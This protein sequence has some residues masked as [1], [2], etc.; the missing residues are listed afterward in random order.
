VSVQ[1]EIARLRASLAADTMVSRTDVERLREQGRRLEALRIRQEMVATRIRFELAPDVRALLDGEALQ[2]RGERQLTAAASLEID[3]VGRFEVVPGDDSLLTLEREATDLQAAHHD[4]LR[5]IGVGTLAAAES[6]YQTQQQATKDLEQAVKTLASLAPQGLDA[7]RAEAD[8]QA[9][10]RQDAEAL[11]AKLPAADTSTELSPVASLSDAESRHVEACRRLDTV[12]AQCSEAR[13]A[14]VG[15]RAK[16][17]SAVRERDALRTRLEDASRQQR[18][19]EA[20]DRRPV[21]RAERDTLTQAI[22]ASAASVDAA[23]PELLRQSVDRFRRSAEI[24]RGEFDRRQDQIQLLKGR[25]E[26]AGT[27]GLEE[28]RAELAV[29]AEGARRRCEE[30]SLRAQALDLLLA[31]LDAKRQDLTRRLRAPLQQRIDHYI[32]LLF[33]KAALELDDQLLP[34][35]LTRP[36][37]VRGPDGGAAGEESGD[38]AELSHG[39]REQL[40]VLTRLAYADLLKEAGRPTLVILDD[41]L[42]HSDDQRLAQMKHMLFDAAQRHQ[43]LLFTCHPAAWRD[44]GV[45]ARTIARSQAET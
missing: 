33:P 16:Q 45:P 14:L 36:G 3:G 31:K 7:L 2:G 17:G 37:P 20:G 35:L 39:A 44:M 22:D 32:R 25:L 28:E 11:R 9:V 6:R 1:T 41:A 29:H 19:R 8:A 18:A 13:Q 5:R 23:R 40:G 15:A 10:R 42:V 43:V 34:R 30:L 26:Q 38:V 4:Q 27:Q 24:A 12:I 21:L